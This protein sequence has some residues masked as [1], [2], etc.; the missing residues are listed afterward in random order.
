MTTWQRLI[1]LDWSASRSG[2][3]RQRWSQ[4]VT[5]H[6]KST[7]ISVHRWDGA[8]SKNPYQPTNQPSASQ[9]A[10]HF[11]A[12]QDFP[13]ALCAELDLIAAHGSAQMRAVADR[14][15]RRPIAFIGSGIQRPVRNEILI[16]P[17]AV[18]PVG[19][20]LTHFIQTSNEPSHSSKLMHGAGG[21]PPLVPPQLKCLVLTN[22]SFAP[23]AA[24]RLLDYD[25]RSAR[26]CHDHHLASAFAWDA[27]LKWEIGGERRILSRYLRQAATRINHAP[28]LR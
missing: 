17:Y 16:D 4:R 15:I 1:F 10:H 23:E 3:A 12:F 19:K 2:L 11:P 27:I 14:G 7:S 22:G 28:F 20:S 24:V 5:H 26:S 9:P 6:S 8:I 13:S 18:D 21:G 25:N